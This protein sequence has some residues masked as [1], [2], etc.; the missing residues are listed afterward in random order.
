MDDSFIGLNQVR[1]I[2]AA[3]IGLR[4]LKKEYFS[5]LKNLQRLDLSANEIEQLDIDAFSSEY[6]NNFQLRELDLSY[7]RIH[8]LPTNIFMVLRQPERINLANNRLVE[9]N[10]IF[11][12]NRDAIQYNPI[13]IILSNNS[14]RNDH[15]TNHTFNDLVERGH[16]IELD[17][18]H[19]K[20]AWIDEEIFGKLL[21]NSSYGKSILLLNNNPIQCTNCRNRWLFRIENKQRGWLRSS[22]KLESCIEKKKRLFDYNLNDFGHC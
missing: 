17:L 6:D 18:T 9:L 5:H 22:I 14:I 10:Q 7:N 3:K 12:F 15:F 16:Y 4:S 20:L 1:S 19:N 13:Q 11:R 21:T 2:H 8:H